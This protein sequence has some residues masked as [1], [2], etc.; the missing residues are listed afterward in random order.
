MET[1]GVVKELQAALFPVCA[2]GQMWVSYSIGLVMQLSELG[3]C[4]FK[5]AINT[6][7]ILKEGKF[8]YLYVLNNWLNTL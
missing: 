6:C 3:S 4:N 1:G 2:K 5:Q 8:Y 7:S